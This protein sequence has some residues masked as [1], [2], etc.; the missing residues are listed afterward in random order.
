[1]PI[2]LIKSQ[3][4]EE[5]NYPTFVSEYG[6]IHWNADDVKGDSWGYGTSPKSPEEFINR[7][8]G[9]TEAILNHPKMGGLCYTQLT[10]VEQEQNGLY[11][12]D[13]RTKFDPAIFHAILTQKAA[14]EE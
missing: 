11:T 3:N 12:Y 2:F 14:I 8:K 6:G 13:R 5:M 4:R 9:L 1:M 7:F 10:D